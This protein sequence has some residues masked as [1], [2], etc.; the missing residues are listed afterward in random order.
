MSEKTMPDPPVVP[1]PA[2][3][4]KEFR[5]EYDK[6]LPQAASEAPAGHLTTFF[7]LDLATNT[8]RPQHKDV[9]WSKEG[10][11]SKEFPENTVGFVPPTSE[12]GATTRGVS[13]KSG[14]RLPY[15]ARPRIAFAQERRLYQV[16]HLATFASAAWA[17]DYTIIKVL[18]ACEAGSV[19]IS[20]ENRAWAQGTLLS[21]PEYHFN[22]PRVSEKALKGEIPVLP[23]PTDSLPV[24]NKQTAHPQ[25]KSF[26]AI[27]PK[28]NSNKS[29]SSGGKRKSK[30]GWSTPKQ[31]K[32]KSTPA[33][34]SG[35]SE[36]VEK[37]LPPR[38]RKKPSQMGYGSG[39]IDEPS[40][41]YY[42]SV[43]ERPEPHTL[44]L[45]H[46]WQKLQELKKVSCYPEATT[47]ETAPAMVGAKGGIMYLNKSK[48]DARTS[49]S[50]GLIN[51]DK[52]KPYP[53]RCHSPSRALRDLE[54]SQQICEICGKTV[55]PQDPDRLECSRTRTVVHASCD[56][57]PKKDPSV[58]YV[59]PWTSFV[60]IVTVQAKVVRSWVAGAVPSREPAPSPQNA[61]AGVYLRESR[62]RVVRDVTPHQWLRLKSKCGTWL[63]ACMARLVKL[64]ASLLCMQYQDRCDS[65][66][67]AT[68]AGSVTS[69]QTFLELHG[70]RMSP[71]WARQLEIVDN[72][73]PVELRM[74]VANRSPAADAPVE[75]LEKLLLL[76][77]GLKDDDEDNK[78][79]EAID[80]CIRMPVVLSRPESA[81]FVFDA[82]FQACYAEVSTESAV[83]S[84]FEGPQRRVRA[85]KLFLDAP[86]EDKFPHYDNTLNEGEYVR[87]QVR[88]ELEGNLENGI[89]TTA[90]YTERDG[91]VAEES[92]LREECWLNAKIGRIS[93]RN[94]YS[95]LART[96]SLVYKGTQ[97][98][99]VS[100]EKQQGACMSILR[101]S[102]DPE[103]S[104]PQTTARIVEPSRA[105]NTGEHSDSTDT[106]DEDSIEEG[107]A[108]NPQ[109]KRRS[110][111][112][113]IET[114]PSNVLRGVR[115]WEGGKRDISSLCRIVKTFHQIVANADILYERGSF[116]W[117]AAR[118]VRDG[119]Y[120]S[121]LQSLYNWIIGMSQI[122][123][124]G[125]DLRQ[126]ASE[127]QASLGKDMVSLLA[128]CNLTVKKKCDITQGMLDNATMNRVKSQIVA[129]PKLNP[130]EYKCGGSAPPLYLCFHF[131]VEPKP[132]IPWAPYA[133]GAAL[134]MMLYC[135]N[136]KKIRAITGGSDLFV[137]NFGSVADNSSNK[138]QNEK[139]PPSQPPQKSAKEN[140]GN[141]KVHRDVERD[142]KAMRQLVKERF[143][144]PSVELESSAAKGS[145][146][147]ADGSAGNETF[148]GRTLHF[149]D[150]LNIATFENHRER[151]S[152]LRR[153][154]GLPATKDDKPS[155]ER[156]NE[157]RKPLRKCFRQAVLDPALVQRSIQDDDEMMELPVRGEGADAQVT[158]KSVDSP[159]GQAESEPE[160]VDW[161][162]HSLL[163]DHGMSS[164]KARAIAS[165]ACTSAFNYKMWQQR[166]DA[167]KANTAVNMD[168]INQSAFE[169]DLLS[170]VFPGLCGS[171][172]SGEDD[173]EIWADLDAGLHEGFL[174]LHP[175]C[176]SS[177]EATT[178]AQ[179]KWDEVLQEKR[180][181]RGGALVRWDLECEDGN[182]GIADELGF[183]NTCAQGRLA[184]IA[185]FRQSIVS[186]QETGALRD[187]AP[188]INGGSGLLSI[189]CL[190]QVH[191]K[192][193]LA[194]Q[195]A[196]ARSRYT[197]DALN[198]FV[199]PEKI[200]EDARSKL[201]EESCREAGNVV[202]LSEEI[203]QNLLQLNGGDTSFDAYEVNDGS[204]VL[205]SNISAP[206]MESVRCSR[207]DYLPKY[208]RQ[209][210]YPFSLPKVEWARVLNTL[211]VPASSDTQVNESSPQH[212]ADFRG[213]LADIPSTGPI[214]SILAVVEWVSTAVVLDEVETSIQD[215]KEGLFEAMI[216]PQAFWP[217][218]S[219]LSLCQESSASETDSVLRKAK[220]G[221][222]LR[223]GSVQ[224]DFVSAF[225]VP[226]WRGGTSASSF[227]RIYTTAYASA[228]RFNRDG[229]EQSSGQNKRH[230]SAGQTN[231][232]G[233]GVHNSK[234]RKMD[235]G[236]PLR[237][238]G[239]QD[240]YWKNIAHQ[241]AD[242]VA[243]ENALFPSEPLKRDSVTVEGIFFGD[244]TQCYACRFGHDHQCKFQHSVCRRMS[245]GRIMSP[246][247]AAA[248]V[249]KRA[250]GRYNLWLVLW[251]QQAP[252]KAD[253]PAND[254]VD[255]LRLNNG[256][257]TLDGERRSSDIPMWNGSAM[258]SLFQKADVD[259]WNA[260]QIPEMKKHETA[261]EHAKSAALRVS[262]FSFLQSFC[263]SLRDA[264]YCLP[265]GSSV[266]YPIGG[267]SEASPA[268]RGDTVNILP[269]YIGKIDQEFQSP[270]FPDEGLPVRNFNSST[271]RQIGMTPAN[272][273]A[274]YTYWALKAVEQQ[275]N[276]DYQRFSDVS[277][278]LY[279]V[280]RV[281]KKLVSSS[282]L[283]GCPSTGS[284]RIEKASIW[285]KREELLRN[286]RSG[287][288]NVFTSNGPYK[289]P[290]PIEEVTNGADR[291][292]SSV[293][294]V[295]TPSQADDSSTK[296]PFDPLQHL[297][298]LATYYGQS[299]EAPK[300][301]PNKSAVVPVNKL[302][303]RAQWNL[304][305]LRLGCSS[306]DRTGL[307]ATQDVDADDVLAE[308]VGEIIGN[309][310]CELR[311]VLY[312]KLGIADYMF[313][314][315]TDEVIDASVLGSRARYINHSCDPNCYAVATLPEQQ[316][317]QE[318]E[319]DDSEKDIDNSKESSS[320]EQSIS[321][322]QARPSKHITVSSKEGDEWTLPL[323][324]RVEDEWLQSQNL[325]ETMLVDKDARSSQELPKG[326]RLLLSRR[327]CELLS[328]SHSNRRRVFVYSARYIRAGEELTYDYQFPMDERKVACKCG[329]TACR[330]TIN[331]ATG[332]LELEDDFVTDDTSYLTQF[333]DQSQTSVTSSPIPCPSEE[334]PAANSPHY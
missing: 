200:S 71:L 228:F 31:R 203:L 290:K 120:R 135:D 305:R 176:R 50:Y 206:E 140:E 154:D 280:L 66:T 287:A 58:P 127:L 95:A 302:A 235:G 40:Y 284:A 329:S 115:L 187:A 82:M 57:S 128:R 330:G 181:R 139:T 223:F 246:I 61:L 259:P 70:Y 65:G 204:K 283:L 105:P 79:S 309:G 205:C 7:V 315:G 232:N 254:F 111:F 55:S 138:V 18:R 317:Q 102:L 11:L 51:K 300:W 150:A 94:T 28:T 25:A 80:Q 92:D 161:L 296:D 211:P 134:A 268:S 137:D 243:M 68:D 225:R 44:H 106:S 54:R 326:I 81:Q 208:L 69:P 1:S 234:S 74:A 238:A 164:S 156:P 191:E 10:D 189:S 148:R 255:H 27:L 245:D 241:T 332:E 124:E 53:P 198:A 97:E 276:E 229:H 155:G 307:Y 306:I 249:V 298:I 4:T 163:A 60:D 113:F 130:C 231:S 126:Q 295:E 279:G 236:R 39:D 297:N 253:V 123:C 210:L 35:V 207:Y 32:P 233:A 272:E 267:P 318:K 125:N 199:N 157:S 217:F 178:A 270:T 286:L 52:V 107:H 220:I 331:M 141:K 26:S 275:C 221:S 269:N 76:L 175:G 263:M 180:R 158:S 12:Q 151:A 168:P 333:G 299:A 96:C 281:W 72:R 112:S 142:R 177:E 143:A 41:S 258:L 73:V 100:R 197:H 239:P 291:F 77:M 146:G 323:C 22:F 21:S 2:G 260:Y 152:A 23:A 218:P 42:S 169:E 265:I 248:L 179:R 188:L 273:D 149:E 101:K 274:F 213:A 172:L 34:S 36:T 324:R 132:R 240:T 43:R 312:D 242:T 84:P 33:V 85:V 219:A 304:A 136:E 103:E 313:R 98:A 62:E 15:H 224:D 190:R 38:K 328:D 185:E 186:Q 308:Y 294:L 171:I 278:L 257:S 301:E 116:P 321:R 83:N 20:T 46:T 110:P 119:F 63:R 170:V 183:Y 145:V 227:C 314:I 99:F 327:H 310:V 5:Y 230:R 19:A 192:V 214:A 282:S 167:H 226:S 292:Q 325:A 16:G 320:E 144:L 30:K 322:K 311:E 13:V 6:R 159:P 289:S 264:L 251:K 49:K 202:Q 147:A 88:D 91:F 256:L 247:E 8:V 216:N 117:R 285:S 334:S 215:V 222:V 201:V 56:R 212:N 121:L 319:M 244:P 193:K 209:T 133:S 86:A 64:H 29:Q 194:N 17:C 271:Y 109:S 45:R 93:L 165:R 3:S 14:E 114:D 118:V 162:L 288:A 104:I 252:I 129:C 67:V 196:K 293:T 59:E 160:P 153:V 195:A 78:D 166:Q 24:M 277:S 184:N 9:D 90:V 262:P 89:D 87:R 303:E 108:P 250:R 47:T 237:D 173:A 131:G 316:Q 261:S 122:F 266:C 37:K 174:A 48:T 75:H 182:A